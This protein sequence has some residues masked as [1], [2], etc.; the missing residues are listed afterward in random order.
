[1]QGFYVDIH[2]KICDVALEVLYSTAH[3]TLHSDIVKDSNKTH[4][5]HPCITI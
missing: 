5:G 3:L 2:N 1:M 4:P